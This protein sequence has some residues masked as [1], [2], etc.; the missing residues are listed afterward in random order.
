MASTRVEQVAETC[1]WMV[2]H[3]IRIFLHSSVSAVQ[4]WTMTERS[5][6]MLTTALSCSTPMVCSFSHSCNSSTRQVKLRIRKA[7]NCV[8]ICIPYLIRS[9]LTLS[10]TW[11]WTKRSQCQYRIIILNLNANLSQIRISNNKIQWECLNSLL[12]KNI[13]HLKKKSKVINS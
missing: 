10:N 2:W 9:K 3:K 13:N 7:L 11:I 4:D 12:R 1:L 5:N 6:N 8:W